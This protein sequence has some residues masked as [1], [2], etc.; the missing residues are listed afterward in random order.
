MYPREEPQQPCPDQRV[1]SNHAYLLLAELPLACL[2]LSP[3]GPSA[4][5]QHHLADLRRSEE[6]ALL[7][8]QPH[9]HPFARCSVF[10]L[11]D[12]PEFLQNI[13]MWGLSISFTYVLYPN[14]DCQWVCGC[15]RGWTLVF[16]FC[17]VSWPLKWRCCY[18]RKSMCLPST[19]L[20]LSLTVLSLIVSKVSVCHINC[21]HVL[22]HLVTLETSQVDG[23]FIIKVCKRNEGL[24]RGRDSGWELTASSKFSF[25]DQKL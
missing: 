17:R 11:S 12:F 8:P 19:H 6:E 22:K 20:C 24:G 3:P 10:L 18:L 13:Y 14:Q 23:T 1:Q 2:G 9:L 25:L 5:F 4:A 15:V 7:G 21:F 16:L